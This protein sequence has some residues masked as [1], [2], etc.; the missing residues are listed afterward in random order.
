MKFHEMI[1]ESRAKN[2]WRAHISNY[3]RLKKR[4]KDYSTEDYCKQQQVDHNAFEAWLKHIEREDKYV[5]YVNFA[6]EYIN[7][8]KRSLDLIEEYENISE[9]RMPLL[10]DVIT[11][12]AAPFTSSRGRISNTLRLQ[13]NLIP[14]SLMPVHTKVC[15]D[16]DQ[17]I[18]HCDIGA[19]DPR[20]SLIGTSIRMAGYYWQDYKALVP[21]LKKLILA[22]QEN[23]NQYNQ[24]TFT[25]KETY[26][27]DSIDSPKSA[28]EDPGPPSVNIP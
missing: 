8:A 15:A 27:Q 20:V 2:N 17:V 25:P 3:I 4:K 9:L 18:G 7:R 23:L 26:F 12:Y 1:K 19:R 21:D 13:E 28:D 24:Q 6:T 22:V 16:R 14:H 10:R 11:A 5:F